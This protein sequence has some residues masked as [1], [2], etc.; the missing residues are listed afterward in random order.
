[1]FS[2]AIPVRPARRSN[3]DVR[4]AERAV[5]VPLW[6]ADH[7]VGESGDYALTFRKIQRPAP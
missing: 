6:E 5:G 7:V 1:M 4:A 2:V 3:A